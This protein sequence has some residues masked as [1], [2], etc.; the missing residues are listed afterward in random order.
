MPQLRAPARQSSS[1]SVDVAP[2]RPSATTTRPTEPTTMPATC[3]AVGSSRS[4]P[5]A[6][7][8]VKMTW[9]WSTRA[10]SPGGIPACREA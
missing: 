2:P 7:T 1:A 9:A 10:A 6:I 4:A 3:A 8:T 5:A